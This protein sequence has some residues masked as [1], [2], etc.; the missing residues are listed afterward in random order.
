MSQRCNDID[1]RGFRLEI[2]G[3]RGGSQMEAKRLKQGSSEHLGKTITWGKKKKKNPVLTI[4]S[5][6]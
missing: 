3:W 1:F 2:S 5:A 6:L 4:Q